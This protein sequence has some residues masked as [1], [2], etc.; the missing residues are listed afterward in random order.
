MLDLHRLTADH[1]GGRN[2]VADSGLCRTAVPHTPVA[3]HPIGL[4]LSVMPAILP[5]AELVL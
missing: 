5:G 1:V 4:V 2:N 3:N